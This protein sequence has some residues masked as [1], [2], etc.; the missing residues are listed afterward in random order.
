MELLDIST[1][2]AVKYEPEYSYL[3]ESRNI[4]DYFEINSINIEPPG[5]QR[6]IIFFEEA[7]DSNSSGS[8]NLASSR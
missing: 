2:Q 8:R 5:Q 7:P 3:A 1:I 4:N 6:T